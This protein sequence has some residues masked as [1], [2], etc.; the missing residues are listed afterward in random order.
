M[1]ISLFYFFLKLS[2]TRVKY[3]LQ[4]VWL[5]VPTTASLPC[6]L[7]SAVCVCVWALWTI[8]EGKTPWIRAQEPPFQTEKGYHKHDYQIK[9]VCEVL[10]IKMFSVKCWHE[11]NMK[12]VEEDSSVASQI[13]RHLHCK[14]AHLLFSSSTFYQRTHFFYNSCSCFVLS[15]Q[16]V[17]CPF[18]PWKAVHY[19]LYDKTGRVG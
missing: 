4:F 13:W 9:T 2:A 6:C 14:P 5:T 12:R 3:Y 17:S 1:D 18:E 7:L 10:Q 11:D 16:P 15:I 19:L 8:I